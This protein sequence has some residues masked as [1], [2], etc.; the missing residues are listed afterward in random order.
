MVSIVWLVYFIPWT[1]VISC[2]HRIVLVNIFTQGN[3]FMKKVHN[4][5]LHRSLGSSEKYTR[6]GQVTLI[7]NLEFQH[8]NM[9][10]GALDDLRLHF[11]L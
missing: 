9:R 6:S 8:F 2:I 7:S 5:Y 4:V 10:F 3:I 11:K 1:W